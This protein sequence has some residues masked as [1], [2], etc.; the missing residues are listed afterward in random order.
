M[1]RE[2]PYAAQFDVI[3]AGGRRRFSVGTESRDRDSDGAIP[4]EAWFQG[5]E[6]RL[7]VEDDDGVSIYVRWLSE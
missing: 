4:T 1:D 2:E 7:D 6:Y 5:E 3:S